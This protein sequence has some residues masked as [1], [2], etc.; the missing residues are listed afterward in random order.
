MITR[1]P[2]NLH[3]CWQ[4]ELAQAYTDPKKLLEDLNLDPSDFGNALEARKLFPMRVPR[5]FVAAMTPGDA[6]DPLLAQVLPAAEEF[7]ATP[8][9][10]VDPLEEQ[11]NQQPGVLH[12][13][14]SRALLMFKGGCAV[15][16][17]Y[18]F[19]RHFPYEENQL[20]REALNQA[21]EYLEAQPELN[22]V[23]LSGGDPLMAKDNQLFKLIERLE[24]MPNI[25]R[26]RIHSRLPV[27]LPSRL[28]QALA[29]RLAQSP[30]QIILVLHCNHPNEITSGLSLGINRLKHA[31]VTILNQSVLLKGVNDDVD[32]M[33]ALNEKLFAN[34]ILPYYLHLLDKVQGAAHFDTSDDN[35]RE[36]MAGMLARLP[37]FLVP[38]LVREQG[39]KAS[40]TL[41]DLQLS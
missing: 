41:I 12:K 38:R 34:G 25:I 15:N 17:R 13:Y 39:G 36:L 32:T 28:T 26:L 6:N 40:K 18:C 33:V 4:Q 14:R 23:I 10:S 30:L 5:P 29:D 19:R 35:A 8:G 31:G 27:V 21:L 20:T 9:Y 22:E 16:C 3:D 2:Q 37:G 24:T 1:I 11:D 7:I